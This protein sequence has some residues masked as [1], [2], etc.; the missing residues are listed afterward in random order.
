MLRY[1]LLL[2]LISFAVACGGSDKPASTGGG[3]KAAVEDDA[4]DDEGMPEGVR[5]KYS[6]DKGTATVKGA[7]KFEGKALARDTDMASDKFCTNC[8]KD[9]E[10]PKSK[11]Y[12]VGANGEMAN[13][14]VYIK[15]GLS[16]WKFGK[17]KST[18]NMSQDKCVY[19]PHVV[20]MQVGDTL[21][22][23][24]G[25][26]TMHNIH[27]LV[28]D[29]GD[30][31]FNMAQPNQGDVY[32]RTAEWAGFYSM[33]C[34]VHSWMQSFICIVKNPF[35]SV[36]GADGGFSLANLPAGTY[37]LAA[38]HEKLGEQVQTVTVKDGE[39]A[40]VSFTFKK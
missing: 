5:Q 17:G 2:L 14:F 15:D 7:I 24:N 13:V 26:S 10:N 6:P 33:K 36:S 40:E 20:G 35:F 22:I 11:T 30:D 16:G 9:S 28:M 27:S 32:S 29:S 8:Y 38:W 25:D 1:F 21:K 18:V 34:D 39:T 12:V 19:V 37:T 31:W 3:S 23:T 4:G